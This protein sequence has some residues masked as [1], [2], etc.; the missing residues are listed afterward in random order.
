M[1]CSGGK[2]SEEHQH[3]N[4]V[5]CAYFVVVQ[6]EHCED[7]VWVAFFSV[8][9]DRRAYS[10]LGQNEVHQIIDLEMLRVPLE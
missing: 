3:K 2:F 6:V 9:L 5:V 1:V 4:E 10:W 8:A 7:H